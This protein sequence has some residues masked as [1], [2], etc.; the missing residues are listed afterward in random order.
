MEC[1]GQFGHLCTMSS[2]SSS[3]FSLGKFFQKIAWFC[4]IER[5]CTSVCAC[6]WTDI[7]G[8]LITGNSHVF[9]VLQ[10]CSQRIFVNFIANIT[11]VSYTHW[12]RKKDLAFRHEVSHFF[13]LNE[14]I[15][16]VFSG[17]A[18]HGMMKDMAENPMKWAGRKILFI[19]TGGLLGLFD[20]TAE[21]V[22]LVGNWRE[23]DVPEST[24]RKDGSGKMF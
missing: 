22:S 14:C 7:G 5:L 15:G 16:H 9:L 18:A 17:K 11:R 13:L 20:K 4:W 23:M 12:F 2:L 8:L 21:M 1:K 19:H 10:G 24:L 6:E 3:L